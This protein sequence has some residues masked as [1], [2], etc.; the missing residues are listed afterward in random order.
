MDFLIDR[1][2]ELE[3]R[4]GSPVMSPEW[5]RAGAATLCP[6]YD[7]KLAVREKDGALDGVAPIGRLKHFMSRLEVLGTTLLTEEGGFLYSNTD[8]LMEMVEAIIQL[9]KPVFLRRVRMYSE[10]AKIW[11]KEI[12]ARGLRCLVR[13]ERLPWVAVRSDWKSFEK[14]QISSSRRSI[15]RRLQRLAEQKGEFK[16]EAV[17]P[18]FENLDQYLDEAFEV[19]VSNWKARRRTAMKYNERLGGFFREYARLATESGELRLFFLRV[20]EEPIAVELTTL[21]GNRIWILKIGH[22]EAWWRCS[23]GILLMHNVIR[24]CFENGLEGCEFGGTDEPW[25]HIWANESHSAWTYRIYPGSVKG[26]F[27]LGVDLL[28]LTGGKIHTVAATLKARKNSHNET[29]QA[30]N[31]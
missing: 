16:F 29:G 26:M 8:A 31:N 17:V 18:T 25:L 21:H 22:N 4:F 24:F 10:E 23:P 15:F 12:C 11:E 9:D 30:Q 27:Q 2:T 5:F 3:K 7:L 28:Q 13:E 6:P 19:E 20:N 14:Q 1:W